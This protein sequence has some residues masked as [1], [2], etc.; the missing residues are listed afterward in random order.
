MDCRGWRIVNLHY[1]TKAQRRVNGWWIAG[2]AEPLRPMV[3]QGTGAAVV[4]EAL[5]GTAPEIALSK[6]EEDKTDAERHRTIRFVKEV[7]RKG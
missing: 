7:T 2:V 3:G 1:D 6:V 4:G 5:R